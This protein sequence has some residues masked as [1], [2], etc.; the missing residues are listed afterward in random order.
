M[1]KNDKKKKKR[2]E[3]GKDPMAVMG[4]MDL[5]CWITFKR[6]QTF[7]IIHLNRDEAMWGTRVK[8]RRDKYYL[9]ITRSIAV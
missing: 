9:V 4:G 8:S 1:K 5:A 3:G 7:S 2:R 6:S